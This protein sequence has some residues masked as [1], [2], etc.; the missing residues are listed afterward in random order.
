VLVEDA[1]ATERHSFELQLAPLRIERV[2]GGMYR[3]Q[4]A[5]K[6]SYG[7]LPRTELEV[8]APLVYRTQLAPR[9]GLAGVGI[10]GLHNFNNESLWLPALALGGEV[11]VPSGAAGTGQ[12]TVAVKGLATRTFGFGRVHVNASYGTYKLGN[13]RRRAESTCP[14]GGTTCDTVPP[15]PPF[16]PDTP[17]SAGSPIT[18]ASSTVLRVRCELQVGAAAAVVP[19]TTTTAGHR[20]LVGLAADHTFPL[21]SLLI[22]GD[23]YAEHYLGLAR[24]VDWTAEVGAR[25]QLTPRVVVD[26]GGGRRFARGGQSWF[27]AAGATYAFSIRALMGLTR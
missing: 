2:V 18:P 15:P 14:T 3:W 20:W 1:T 9:A 4:V 23:V 7:I 11:L 22:V 21:R 12:S 6:I 17:C 8:R 13:L 10:G 5:P 24:P 26:A 25:R 27:A 19:G 16:I